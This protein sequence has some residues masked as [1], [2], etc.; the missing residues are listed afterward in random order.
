[1]NE[2][3]EDLREL[4]VDKEI[5]LLQFQLGKIRKTVS[6]KRLAPIENLLEVSMMRR[7]GDHTYMSF[8]NCDHEV[9]GERAFIGSNKNVRLVGLY[10]WFYRGD[11]RG[12]QGNYSPKMR[13]VFVG[14]RT[15]LKQEVQLQGKKIKSIRVIH[16]TKR[17]YSISIKVQTQNGLLQN[18]EIGYPPDQ[19]SQDELDE[20]TTQERNIPNHQY[21]RSIIFYTSQPSGAMDGGSVDNDSTRLQSGHTVAL[22]N[23]SSPSSPNKKLLLDASISSSQQF[24]SSNPGM[25]IAGFTLDVVL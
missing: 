22:L 15:N 4:E 7:E 18:I 13:S 9:P 17:I 2:L 20:Y 6:R 11:L 5:E 12:I 21:I 10:V 1:M 25:L 3:T 16:G 24:A 8:G 14:Q 23:Q 19:V